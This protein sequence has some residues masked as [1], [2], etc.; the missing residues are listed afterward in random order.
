[1]IQFLLSYSFFSK[2]F[3][4]NFSFGVLE[5]DLKVTDRHE[6]VGIYFPV[7]KNR[8]KTKQDSVMH[9]AVVTGCKAPDHL[10]QIKIEPA[11]TGKH[12]PELAAGY[13]LKHP[14]NWDQVSNPYNSLCRLDH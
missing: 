11:P 7:E 9:V 5:Q 12:A 4:S 3:K 13:A 8:G 1:M 14:I 2:I 10:Q 6:T